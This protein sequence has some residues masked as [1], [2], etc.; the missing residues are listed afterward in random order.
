[1]TPLYFTANAPKVG[2]IYKNNTIDVL[3]AKWLLV[4]TARAISSNA[5]AVNVHQ[6]Q[7]RNVK[8]FAQTELSPPWELPAYL[9]LVHCKGLSC[10]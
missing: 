4:A 10:Q 3:I 2:E 8:F 7:T 9:T 6:P 5:D 1:M